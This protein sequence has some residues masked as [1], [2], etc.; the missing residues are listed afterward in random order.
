MVGSPV[1]RV[2]RRDVEQARVGVVGRV[3]F[4]P[5]EMYLGGTADSASAPQG[6]L[7][8][9]DA[10]DGSVRW[11]YHS[12]EPMVAAVT[13]TAGGLVFTGEQTG[14]FLALDASTGEVRYRFYTGGGIFGGVASYA[15]DG[16]QYVAVTSGGGS[17][18]FGGGGS[19][20]L[21]VFGLGVG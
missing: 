5:G 3:R 8:A 14:D 10:S 19:P 7:T 21:F 9:V 4:I 6:W 11:R 18:T 12:A 15:V 17:L 1:L 2:L 20:T 16:R 13:T